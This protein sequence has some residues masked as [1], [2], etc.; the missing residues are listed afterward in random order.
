MDSPAKVRR[1]LYGTLPPN[2]RR[3]HTVKA[4][5]KNESC[6]RW[7]I[8]PQLKLWNFVQQ[9]HRNKIHKLNQD[10]QVFEKLRSFCF[11]GR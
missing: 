11:F 7:L 2:H 1:I 10:L 9:P 5:Y 8:H 6:G 4:P 3:L